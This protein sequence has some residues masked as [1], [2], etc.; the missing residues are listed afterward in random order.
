MTTDAAMKAA[1]GLPPFLA[2]RPAAAVSELRAQ[3]NLLLQQYKRQLDEGRGLMQTK[4]MGTDHVLPITAVLFALTDAIMNDLSMHANAVAAYLLQQQTPTTTLG[5][6]P[7]DADELLD[8][9]EGL[10]EAMDP[11]AYLAVTDDSPAL[12]PS[13]LRADLTAWT[14]QLQVLASR[15]EEA[16]LDDDDEDDEGEDDNS[17]LGFDLT[18]EEQPQQ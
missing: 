12:E 5:L 18:D 11:D 4:Q 1:Q 17:L 2:Y 8:M 10:R 3:A 7:E 14:E 16:A 6:H 13:K 9:V 15:I